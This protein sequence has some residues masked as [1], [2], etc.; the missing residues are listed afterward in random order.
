MGTK[1]C[2]RSELIIQ[3]LLIAAVFLLFY[4]LHM[5]IGILGNSGAPESWAVV[6]FTHYNKLLVEEGI[7]YHLPK[8]R[9]PE[10]E[11]STFHFPFQNVSR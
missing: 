4:F 2:A 3:I 5:K 8:K 7:Q 11:M 1:K 9:Q 10:D 6:E